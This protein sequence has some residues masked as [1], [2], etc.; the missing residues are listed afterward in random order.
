MEPAEDS[1]IVEGDG[2]LDLRWRGWKEIDPFTF[3][4]AS[5]VVFLN[6]S[7]NQLNSLP[8]ELSLFEMLKVLNLNNNCLVK[9]PQSIGSLTNLEELR[10]EHNSLKALP[11]EIGTCRKLRILSLRNNELS[12]L[13]TTI[14]E[15]IR[16]K[17]ID[18]EENDLVHVP[19]E[20]SKLKE[21]LTKISLRNNKNLT[22]I[23]DKMH[24]N[25]EAILEILTLL[26]SKTNLFYTIKTS[27]CE[28]SSLIAK[29]QIE[30]VK[31]K[32]QIEELQ[33]E[34]KELQDVKNS[35]QRYLLLKRKYQ[36]AKMRIKNWIAFVKRMFSKDSRVAIIP[37]FQESTSIQ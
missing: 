28:M 33:I 17:E 35:C 2:T 20:I 9:L 13:P 15:C 10:V 23:P 11:D 37:E 16:L 34:K 32:A 36:S 30:I 8:G 4:V 24:D 3:S 12:R 22:T 29:N 19:Y 21:T 14:E 26:Y 5:Q 31:L 18:L 1:I 6:L 7:S 25:T 27:T